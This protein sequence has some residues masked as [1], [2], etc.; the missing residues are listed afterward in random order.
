M[1]HSAIISGF[2]FLF[3]KKTICS[4]FEGVFDCEI[5][6]TGC[7]WPPLFTCW[8]RPGLLR[9]TLELATVIKM[10]LVQKFTLISS[11]LQSWST[12]LSFL[13]EKAIKF[14]KLIDKDDWPHYW[15]SHGQMASCD[16][17]CDAMKPAT[18]LVNNLI[19]S[20]CRSRYVHHLNSLLWGHQLFITFNKNSLLW[21]HQLLN[22]FCNRFFTIFMVEN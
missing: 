5:T 11:L 6:G 20:Y 7:T 16:S 9:A 15:T 18:T 2:L 19:C 21:G 4:N 3:K 12:I 10:Y 13:I 14:N 22:L 17:S 8:I 1:G